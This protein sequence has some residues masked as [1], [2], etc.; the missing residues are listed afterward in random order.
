MLRRFSSSLLQ[1]RNL[2]AGEA[3]ERGR[4]VVLC[5]RIETGLLEAALL[6]QEEERSLH[7]EQERCL[8]RHNHGSKDRPDLF[9][10]LALCQ[11]RNS[12]PP[13][14]FLSRGRRFPSLIVKSLSSLTLVSSSL[15]FLVSASE[16]EDGN[17]SNMY[18]GASFSSST[19]RG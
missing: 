16:G 2:S 9:Q 3:D 12:T 6:A 7:Q 14:S 4:F 19:Q 15:L 17:S 8:Q 13:I 1:L 10:H 18:A 5:R 11:R